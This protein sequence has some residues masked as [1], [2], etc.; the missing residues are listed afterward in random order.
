MI[1]KKFII[2][3]HVQGV[4]FRAST[5]QQAEQ[6]GLTG[7]AK[8]LTDG[9]VEVVAF[10]EEPKIQQLQQWLWLGPEH[11]QVTLVKEEPFVVQDFSNFST[12]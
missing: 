7:Y 8:N 6:L 4:F 11:A 2:S 12:D 3:G 5:K 9:K 10:G 1:C